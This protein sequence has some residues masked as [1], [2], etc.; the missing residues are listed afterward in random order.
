MIANVC[1]F[2]ATSTCKHSGKKADTNM[3]FCKLAQ[4]I[5]SFKS[6]WQDTSCSEQVTTQNKPQLATIMCIVTFLINKANITE[7]PST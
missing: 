5:D 4:V 1:S 2:L 6:T 7:Y 3:C